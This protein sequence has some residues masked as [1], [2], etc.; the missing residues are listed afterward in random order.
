MRISIMLAIG[1]L[2][3]VLTQQASHHDGPL[4]SYLRVGPHVIAFESDTL[5]EGAKRVALVQSTFA[6]ARR[7]L[8]PAALEVRGDAGDV[9]RWV[10]YR[11]GG[12][13]PMSLVLES[14]EMGG[15][16]RVTGFEFVV[17]GSRP[18]LERRCAAL[19]VQGGAVST[20]TG[21]RLGLA[22]REVNERLG[23]VGRDSAGVVV[24]DRTRQRVWHRADGGQDEYTESAGFVVRYVRGRVV[25]F[26]G[27][28]VDAS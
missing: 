12:K 24:Y 17:A 3:A 11:L 26:S 6:D 21:L 10:C 28:R 1:S 25:A 8:G 7:K 15:G 18:D 9:L 19:S 13:A 2:S 27:Y 4:L 14:D 5:T 16:K 22:R 23:V 20:N